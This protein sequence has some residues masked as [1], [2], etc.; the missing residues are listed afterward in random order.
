M[1]LL[2]DECIGRE[3]YE[4]FCIHLDTAS[5]PIGHAHILD[6]NRKQGIGDEIWVPRAAAEGWTVITGDA[7]A[8][9]LGAP[10]QIIMPQFGVTGIYFSGKLQQKRGAVKLQALVAVLGQLA[11]VA[12]AAK[13]ERFRLH[14]TPSGGFSL[15]VW[16]LSKREASMVYPRRK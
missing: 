6:F 14:L 2:I 5:S 16:P 1:K 10:L 11:T 9:K 3:I 15:R 4:Q 7:G 8:S 13:G 12:A